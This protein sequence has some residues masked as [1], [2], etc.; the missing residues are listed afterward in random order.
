MSGLENKRYTTD[1]PNLVVEDLILLLHGGQEGILGQVVG[2]G[3]VLFIGTVRLLLKGLDGL[4][5]QT[6][7]VE[8]STLVGRM[9]RALVEGRVV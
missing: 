6:S 5:E 8:V 7:E 4:G 2:T 1:L 9:S 3:F